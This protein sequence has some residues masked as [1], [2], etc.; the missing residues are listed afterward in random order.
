MQSTGEVILKVVNASSQDL[1]TDIRFDGLARLAG[2][3]A[4]VVLTSGSPTDENSLANPTRVAPVERRLEVAGR[5]IHH[6][7]PGNSVTVI[8]VKGE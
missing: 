2:P 4:A 7:F 1:A 3:A 5:G 8:R 6:T